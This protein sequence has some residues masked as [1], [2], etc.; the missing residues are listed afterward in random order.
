LPA[1]YVDLVDTSLAGGTR[2]A[3]ASSGGPVPARARQQRDE[4]TVSGMALYRFEVSFTAPA[5]ERMIDALYEAGWDDATVSLDPAVGGPGIAAFDREAISAVEAIASAI[6][7]G[8]S[9]GATITAVGEDLVSLTEIAERAGRTVATADHWATGRRGPGNFPQPKI[10]R[11]RASLY[12]WAEVASWLHG[13]GLAEV[14]LADVETARVCEIADSLVRAD[15]L[16]RELPPA[17]RKR[18]TGAMR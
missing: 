4:G 16:Q 9:A 3:L 1:T 10:G 15:R 12:S 14:S 17:D 2:Q 6:R 13:H 7:Q 18:L 8:R 5:G 11:P